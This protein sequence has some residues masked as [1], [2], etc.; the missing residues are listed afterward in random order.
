MATEK[1][2]PLSIDNHQRQSQ[3]KWRRLCE[4]LETAQAV[5]L[6]RNCKDKYQFVKTYRTYG[7]SFHHVSTGLRASA[8]L[9]QYGFF[10]E[11]G[12]HHKIISFDL[13]GARRE[14]EEKALLELDSQLPIERQSHAATEELTVID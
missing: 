7:D 8:R 12:L 2:E 6:I 10:C 1:N 9:G 13:G 4:T 5:D 11:R 14:E 3:T